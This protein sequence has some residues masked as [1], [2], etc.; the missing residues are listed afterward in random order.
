[1]ERTEFTSDEAMECSRRGFTLAL[2]AL[3]GL[4]LV[5][6]TSA[7][8]L[9][10]A[11]ADRTFQ[12]ARSHLVRLALALLL[13]LVAGRVR[14]RLL[15]RAAPWLLLVAVVALLVTLGS[16]TQVNGSRRWLDLGLISFQPSELARLAVVLALG[17]WAALMGDRMQRVLPGVLVPFGL[18]GL[19]ALLVFFEP[20]YGSSVYLLFVGV[21]LLWIAGSQVRHLVVAFGVALGGASLYGLTHF[22]H[23]SKRLAHFTEPATGSQVWQALVALGSGGATGV[24]LGAGR[25]KWGFVPEAENDFIL[26]VLGEELGLVGGLVLLALYGLLLFHGTRLLLGLRSRFALVVG[27]GLLFQVA[28]QALLNIAVV[29]AMAPPKGLPLP[30]VSMGGSSLLVLSASCGLLLGLAARPEE[31]PGVAG[32]GFVDLI[33]FWRRR[34]A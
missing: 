29:T 11:L 10:D 19:P 18:I 5:L 34:P 23:M 3:M 4:G 1:M 17:A 27:A 28:V 14:P 20:D 6:V 16:G 21:L 25:G 24:G 2:F 30:F 8:G 26:T 31:D 33:A 13:F 15:V 7:T 22:G 12:G 9:G 32:L